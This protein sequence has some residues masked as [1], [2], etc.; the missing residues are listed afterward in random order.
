[1]G[2]TSGF[3]CPA[4]ILSVDAIWS[5]LADCKHK[6]SAWG[7]LTC[8][9]AALTLLNA[10]HTYISV[11]IFISDWLHWLYIAL[12]IF[13]LSLYHYVAHGSLHSSPVMKH[14]KLWP[15]GGC[16]PSI[17]LQVNKPSLGNWYLLLLGPPQLFHDPT[18]NQVQLHNVHFTVSDKYVCISKLMHIYLLHNVH[19]IC[20]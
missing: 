14:Q 13:V 7:F 5:C 18:S 12:H 1:M 17:G 6:V 9:L 2:R 8:F 4:E 15:V 11:W 19:I 3:S 10:S 16:A 20:T